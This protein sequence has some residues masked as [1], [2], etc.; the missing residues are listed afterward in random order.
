MGHIPLRYL[1]D[2]ALLRSQHEAEIDWG[3]VQRGL[4]RQGYQ[5]L[6]PGYLYLADRLIGAQMP[7]SIPVT[8]AAKRH[9]ERV[10]ELAPKG[11]DI[12]KLARE[13]KRAL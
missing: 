8:P 1:H 12:Y 2:L 13:R 11:A 7:E 6:V 3:Q 10:L 9:Y 5:Y 4:S